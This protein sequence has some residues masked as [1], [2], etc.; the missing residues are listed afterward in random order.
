MYVVF[1]VGTVPMMGSV[2]NVLVIASAY[3]N[4]NHN[5]MQLAKRQTLPDDRWR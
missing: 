1:G 4:V 5:A 3:R 2:P